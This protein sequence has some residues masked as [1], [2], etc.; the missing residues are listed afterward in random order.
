MRSG[1]MPGEIT[2]A[3][4]TVLITGASAGLGA[5]LALAYAEPGRTLVLVAR[6]AEALAGTAARCEAQGADVVTQCCDVRD[7]G[8]LQRFVAA[9]E[10]VLPG[11]RGIDLAIVNAG[12]FSGRADASVRADAAVTEPASEADEVL[13]VNLAGAIATVDAVLPGMRR[14]RSGRIALISSLAA[15]QPLADAPAYSASKAGLAAYGEA[16]RDLLAGEG[17]GVS[18]VLPGHIQTA[19]TAGHRGPLPLLMTTGDAAQR[20]RRGLDAGR[21]TIAFP[22]RLLW[23]I[24]IGRLLPPGLRRRALAGQRFTVGAPDPN[25]H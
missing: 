7:R 16:L 3:P 8:G 15:L 9:V 19:Q 11:D 5:A 10:R 12:L 25:G 1:I 13:S 24:R 4:R 14:R 21:A 6:R 2:P 23:L 17:I 22:R 20:I 18:V